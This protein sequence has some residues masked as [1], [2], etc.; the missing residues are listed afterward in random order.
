MRHASESGPKKK[1]HP[2]PIARSL[3]VGAPVRPLTEVRASSSRNVVVP[4][5]VAAA[6]AL[7]LS[8]C[9]KASKIERETGRSTESSKETP[10][11][12]GGDSPG[13]LDG[14]MGFIDPEPEPARLAGDIPEPRPPATVTPVNSAGPVAA[15]SATFIPPQPNPPRLA[16]DVADPSPPIG[17][18]PTQTVASP[19]PPPPTAIPP[20]PGHPKL[21]GKPVA[22]PPGGTI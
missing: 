7:S 22:H 11:R 3:E 15:P 2:N 19:P 6:L 1:V 17:A 5:A 16:G 4:L 8:G 13:L 14:L 12:A 10:A 9:S 20:N 21:G 18:S